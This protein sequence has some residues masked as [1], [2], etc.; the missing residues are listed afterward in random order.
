MR[1]E[2][3]KADEICDKMSE[4]KGD[5]EI[6]FKM[7]TRKTQFRIEAI[8]KEGNYCVEKG[9]KSQTAE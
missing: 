9:T 3:V 7:E 5:W 1:V 4:Y 6:V 8:G 2:N